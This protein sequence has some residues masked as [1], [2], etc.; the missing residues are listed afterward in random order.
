VTWPSFGDSARVL[1]LMSPQPQVETDSA[2]K[3]NCS[4]WAA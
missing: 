1:S 3:H 2:S 4:F